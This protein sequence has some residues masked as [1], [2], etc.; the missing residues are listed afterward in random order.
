LANFAARPAVLIMAGTPKAI[1]EEGLSRVRVG[2]EEGL[3]RG[4]GHL[5]KTVWRFWGLEV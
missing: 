2:S 1:S 4:K 3:S 5:R